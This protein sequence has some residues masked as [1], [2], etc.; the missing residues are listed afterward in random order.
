MAQQFKLST[1]VLLSQDRVGGVTRLTTSRK[2]TANSSEAV[3]ASDLIY[4]EDTK[5]WEKMGC[6]CLMGVST[7]TRQ[8]RARTQART[9]MGLVGGEVVM[10][11]V[12]VVVVVLVVVVVVVGVG[13]GI[14]I[15]VGVGGKS[16]LRFCI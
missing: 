2:P 14:G 10:V 1:D 15:V 5:T 7:S 3:S 8:T 9:V 13:I 4:S 6:C 16:I 11:V 12:V